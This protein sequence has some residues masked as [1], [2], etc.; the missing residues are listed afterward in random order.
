MQLLDKEEKKEKEVQPGNRRLPGLWQWEWLS[1]CFVGME[2]TP[3][4]QEPAVDFS[5][6]A[7]PKQTWLKPRIHRCPH[8]REGS[9]LDA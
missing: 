9:H 3:V 4:P 1:P 6:S 5:V 2:T 7:C 8:R